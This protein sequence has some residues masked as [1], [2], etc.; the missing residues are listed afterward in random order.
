VHL[1]GHAFDP[2]RSIVGMPPSPAVTLAARCLSSSVATESPAGTPI[3]A[4]PDPAPPPTAASEDAGRRCRRFG[5]LS[6]DRSPPMSFRRIRNGRTVVYLIT[7]SDA[8]S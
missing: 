2:I 8:G 1:M 5:G 4:T 6:I 3:G 7:V